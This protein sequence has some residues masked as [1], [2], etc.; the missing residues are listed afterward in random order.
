MN[1]D[2]KGS[3]DELIDKFVNENGLSLMDLELFLMARGI[4]CVSESEY[5]STEQCTE[6]CKVLKGGE[7]KKGVCEGCDN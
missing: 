3:Q 4:V 6:C 1:E 5:E 7:I 2:L